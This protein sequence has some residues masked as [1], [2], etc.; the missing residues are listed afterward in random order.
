MSN[1]SCTDCLA[2]RAFGSA[3]VPVWDAHTGVEVNTY[4]KV[5]DADHDTAGVLHVTAKYQQYACDHSPM[6]CAV[7]AYV[8]NPT[9]VFS[10]AYVRVPFS[11]CALPN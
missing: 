2:L 9:R 11:R 5:I 6:C 10:S 3:F 1:C 7:A 4:A 8:E